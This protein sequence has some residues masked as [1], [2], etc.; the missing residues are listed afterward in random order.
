MMATSLALP[1]A[2]DVLRRALPN[3]IVVLARENWH[4]KSVVISG[5]VEAGSLFDPAQQEG[6]AS[7]VAEMLLRGTRQR[8]FQAI[9]EWLESCG[10]SLDFSAGRHSVGFAGRSLAEDLPGLVDLLAEALRHPAFPPDQVERLRGQTV[11]AL[12]IH[13]QDTEYVASRL[14]RELVYGNGHP[15]ARPVDGT[16]ETVSRFSRDQLVEFHQRHYGPRQ[17][18][19]VVVGAIEVEAAARLVAERLGDWTNP[20]QPESPS[21]PPVP[22]LNEIERREAILPGKSQTD[23]VLG[24]SG[25]SRFAPDWVAANLANHILGVFGMYGRIG[26]RVRE[27]LGMAYYSYSRLDG[28]LGPGPWRVE[29][30]VNPANVELAIGVIRDELRRITQEPVTEEELENSKSN[31]IGRLPLQLESNEGVAGALLNIERYQLGLDYLLRYADEIRAV[32]VE[33][34]LAAARHY[35]NPDAFALAIA[36]PER[37]GI[38]A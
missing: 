27:Q 36:G 29:A 28:G 31:Y 20:G 5:W 6:L 13:E 25:P 14:F 21:L 15:Y 9:H 7:F 37:A 16:V 11:T 23:L 19:I 18:V 2:H 17:M 34:V 22:A 8:D 26:A 38:P 3:G 35:L 33:D 4:G 10:A 30:G 1:G 24:V 12:K 32:T